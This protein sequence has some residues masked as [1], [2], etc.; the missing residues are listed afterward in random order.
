MQALRSISPHSPVSAHPPES[1]LNQRVSSAWQRAATSISGWATVASTIVAVVTGSP[2]FGLAA[3]VA[4][5]AWLISR[6]SGQSTEGEAREAPIRSASSHLRMFPHDSRAPR[7]DE[8]HAQIRGPAPSSSGGLPPASH[9]LPGARLYSPERAPIG[10][11]PSAPL[12]DPPRGPHHLHGTAIDSRPRA[13]VGGAAVLPSVPPLNLAPLRPA[14]SRPHPGQGHRASGP[15]ASFA[16]H[17]TIGSAPPS[18]SHQSLGRPSR[19]DPLNASVMNRPGGHGHDTRAQI[20]GAPLPRGSAPTLS[21]RTPIGRRLANLDLGL[22]AAGGTGRSEHPPL[23]A[24]TTPSPGE[25]R[26]DL[27]P[28]ARLSGSLGNTGHAPIGRR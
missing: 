8:P 22:V 27:P 19:A 25:L 14:D 26:R 28:P 2:I 24:P 18:S 6:H 4:G 10:G 5:L 23:P 9:P 21:E 1:A 17:A 15:A 16:G 12:G 3:V 11:P 7:Q 13:P 20:G